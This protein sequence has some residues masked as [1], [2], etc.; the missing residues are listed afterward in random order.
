ML[1]SQRDIN[2][3]S[4]NLA[5]MSTS[6]FKRDTLVA[7]T[8]AEAIAIRQQP[9]TIGKHVLLSGMEERPLAGWHPP[10]PPGVPRGIAGAGGAEGVDFDPFEDEVNAALNRLTLSRGRTALETMTDFTQG[11]VHLTDRAV[12]FAL[13]GPGF[14]MVESARGTQGPDNLFGVHGGVYFSRNGQFRLDE[15]GY[16]TSGRIRS[17]PSDPHDL[18]SDH[19]TTGDRIMGFML[20]QPSFWDLFLMDSTPPEGASGEQ[21]AELSNSKNDFFRLMN[22]EGFAGM[23]SEGTL[24]PLRVGTDHFRVD[25]GGFIFLL[26][27]DGIPADAPHDQRVAAA[28]WFQQNFPEGRLIGRLGVF[29]PD[30]P[31]LL[32]KNGEDVFTMLNDDPRFRPNA[33]IFEENDAFG[34]IRNIL[35]GMAEQMS[36]STGIFV[37]VSDEMVAAVAAAFSS[38]VMQGFL[39]RSNTNIS[40]EIS[41]MMMSSRSFQSMAQVIRTIDTLL[42][43][44]I[45][46]VGRTQ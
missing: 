31:H 32:F 26:S 1:T 34:D 5:N 11:G 39:E 12:D 33:I 36:E 45:S 9:R 16:L 17:E 35:E 42:A 46:E 30:N 37:D 24:Q 4:N 7:T 41:G 15:H 2:V 44:S 19:M 29:T 22:E 27:P 40:A 14:F 28:E 8:F 6:G 13:N 18:G 21:I 10:V 3:R 38:T 25:A 20:D 23:A 43:R